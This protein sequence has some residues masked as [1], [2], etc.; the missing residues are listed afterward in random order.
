MSRKYAKNEI[1]FI[2]CRVVNYDFESKSSS[3]IPEQP[4]VT[5]NKDGGEYI[6]E[7]V[8]KSGK[9]DDHSRVFWV[10]E[11]HLISISEAKKVI[12]GR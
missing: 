5:A 9:V 2:R 11:H 10:G 1:V 8:E 6:L 4:N 12:T 7:S 3:L